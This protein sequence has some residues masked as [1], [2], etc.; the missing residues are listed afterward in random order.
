MSQAQVAL[1]QTGILHLSG[2][3]DYSTGNALC[4]QGKKLI[5][6]CSHSNI[7]IDCAQVSKSSSVGVALVLAFI[8][9]TLASSKNYQVRNLPNDMQQIAQVCGLESVLISQHQAE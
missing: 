7:V 3:L 4:E 5:A 6:S 2:V 8:R 1:E 9:A